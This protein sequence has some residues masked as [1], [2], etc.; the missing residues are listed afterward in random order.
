MEKLAED[1]REYGV[2]DFELWNEVNS[3]YFT[4]SS[5]TRR[6]PTAAEYVELLK[7]TY[8]IIHNKFGDEARL[9]A[10]AGDPGENMLTFMEDCFKLGAGEYLDG[11]SIHPYSQSKIPEDPE[12]F[13]KT[14]ADVRAL[15][16]KYGLENKPLINSKQVI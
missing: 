1:V 10:F 7:V 6:T 8:P 16:D 3:Y 5:D 9:F 4:D 12:G 15:M 13:T 11:V 14:I 2:K